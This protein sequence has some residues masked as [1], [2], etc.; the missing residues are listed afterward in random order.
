MMETA[1]VMNR[2]GAWTLRPVLIE[3]S[4]L[5]GKRVG[6][7]KLGRLKVR[8][9]APQKRVEGQGC[10]KKGH[11][12]RQSKCGCCLHLDQSSQDSVKRVRATD[13]GTAD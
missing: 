4:R 13:D 5:L 8:R 6:S 9:N 11:Q 2:G 12:E 3:G 1:A 7:G 10:V